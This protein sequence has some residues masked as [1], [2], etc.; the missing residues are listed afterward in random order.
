VT[1]EGRPKISGLATVP[2]QPS[3]WYTLGLALGVEEEVLDRIEV[4][5]AH[6]LAKCKRAMFRKWLE[7]NPTPLW[8][9]V[10]EALSSIGEQETADRV[11]VEFFP[12]QLAE[13]HDHH[14]DGSYDNDDHHSDGGSG[15]GQ[16]EV[17]DGVC[18]L[19][20]S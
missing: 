18:D 14:A 7:L 5:Q 4:E 12:P 16:D 11:R 20:S 15:S 2:I 10:I 13:S 1:E 17:D 19:V 9:N 6:K 3:Q 8:N